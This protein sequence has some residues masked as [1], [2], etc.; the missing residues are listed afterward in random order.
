[1]NR[2]W[3]KR[4]Q[5]GDTKAFV[6]SR[7]NFLGQAFRKIDFCALAMNRV[8]DFAFKSNAAL[9]AKLGL[10]L[11]VNASVITIHGSIYGSCIRM[12]LGNEL[13]TGMSGYDNNRLHIV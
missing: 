5:A 7:V 2:P 6:I 10:V 3:G 11:A 13:Y 4:Y 8:V 1:M 12:R 9:W